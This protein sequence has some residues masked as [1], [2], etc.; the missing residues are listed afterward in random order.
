VPY[1]WSNNMEVNKKVMTSSPAVYEIMGQAYADNGL[2]L[3]AVFPEGW[4]YWSSNKPLRAMGD[5]RN[6]KIRIM[7][8]PAGRLGPALQKEPVGRSARM[9]PGNLPLR[10]LR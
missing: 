9:E 1:I 6:F 5:F 4:Q 3:L 2:K 7:N 10:R 8:D